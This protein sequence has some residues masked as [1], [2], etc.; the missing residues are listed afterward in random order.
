MRA[1][2][3][4]NLGIFTYTFMLVSVVQLIFD[5]E[6]FNPKGA[7]LYHSFNVNSCYILSIFGEWFG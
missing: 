3:F 7:F 4:R 5:E 1:S 6:N 2:L